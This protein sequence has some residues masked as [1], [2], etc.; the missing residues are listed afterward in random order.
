[1]LL[2]LFLLSIGLFILIK[3]FGYLLFIFMF[4][5]YIVYCFIDILFVVLIIFSSFKYV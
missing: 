1:M 5:M 3:V 2:L 4:S